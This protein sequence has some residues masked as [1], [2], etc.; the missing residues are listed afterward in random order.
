MA[1][2]DK[3]QGAANCAKPETLSPS[4]SMDVT[5]SAGTTLFPS[6]R[7]LHH[8]RETVDERMWNDFTLAPENK[9]LHKQDRVL[10]RSNGDIAQAD[11]RARP[12]VEKDCRAASLAA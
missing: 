12:L 1:D 9:L 4:P 3:Q 8:I 6:I 11:L 7:E 10:I 5:G 2:Q